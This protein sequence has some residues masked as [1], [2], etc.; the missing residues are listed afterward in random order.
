VCKT[1]IKVGDTAKP[2]AGGNG[3]VRR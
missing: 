2:P 3:G 1:A